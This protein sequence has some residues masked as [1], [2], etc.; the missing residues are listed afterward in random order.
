MWG[1]LPQGNDA[2]IKRANRPSVERETMKPDLDFNTRYEPIGNPQ[3]DEN[4]P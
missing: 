4:D 2:L 3:P 1:R